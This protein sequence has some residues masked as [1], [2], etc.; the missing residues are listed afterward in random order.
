MAQ[1]FEEEVQEE[2]NFDAISE[3]IS[4]AVKQSMPEISDKITYITSEKSPTQ[5]GQPNFIGTKPLLQLFKIF[6][7]HHALG[8]DLPIANMVFSGYGFGCAG[9]YHILDGGEKVALLFD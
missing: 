2:G 7:K 9:H 1:Y 3:A 5:L 4:Q 8:F 6:S